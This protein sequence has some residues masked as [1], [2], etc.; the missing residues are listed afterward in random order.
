MCFKKKS[1]PV[2][3]EKQQESLKINDLTEL[4]TKYEIWLIIAFIV[5]FILIVFLAMGETSWYYTTKV[6]FK[7]VKT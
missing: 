5:I 4:L 6:W 7:W 3:L 2:R 1:K